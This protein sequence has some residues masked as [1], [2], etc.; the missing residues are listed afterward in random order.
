MAQQGLFTQGPSVQDLL[1]QRNKRAGDLQQQLMQ[2]AAQG[3]R[4]P[5]KM[6]AASL[7]GSSLGRALAG[8]VG[9]GQD[10]QMQKIKAAQAQQTALQQEALSVSSGTIAEKRAF[11]NKIAPIYPEY[12]Q[13]LNDKVNAQQAA[14][15]QNLA[16]KAASDAALK[17][18]AD[19][20]ATAQ[21]Q[22]QAAIDLKA[23]EQLED[24]LIARANSEARIMED[25][26]AAAALVRSQ[27]NAIDMLGPNVNEGLVKAIQS[28]DKEALQFGWKRITDQHEDG[29]DARE[30]ARIYG[31]GYEV[32]TELNKKKLKEKFESSGVNTTVN[33]N[34]GSREAVDTDGFQL[35]SKTQHSKMQ[36]DLLSTN[37]QLTKLQTIKDKFNPEHFGA[38]GEGR[39]AFGGFLDYMGINEDTYLGGDSVAFAAKRNLS[40]AEIG[41]LFNVYRKEVTGAAAAIAELAA[42]E[43][44]YL[45]SKK[46]PAATLV[47][48]NDLI[49]VTT[50]TQSTQKETLKRGIRVAGPTN[51]D[52]ADAEAVRAAWRAANPKGVVTP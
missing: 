26:D 41:Q 32:G 52:T 9:G 37:K 43:K 6:R 24:D 39:A 7:I 35:L 34:T 29:A 20:Y 13:D 18:A 3:A 27:N 25:Q 50:E 16:D 48:L 10:S 40:Q 46:G 4:N 30:V 31:E 28:G 15:A 19:K 23:Q 11:I 14:D 8:N 21:E 17:L 5:A 49:R 38:Y 36:A 47:M 2:Q 51:W 22:K 42:I 1:S 12:A 33:V 44:V 45:N